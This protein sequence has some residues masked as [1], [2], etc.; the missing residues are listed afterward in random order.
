MMGR[1]KKQSPEEF[2]RD[3]ETRIGEKVLARN[4][5]RY[6]SGWNEFEESGGNPLW[7]L[8]IATEGGFRFHHFPQINWFDALS[9]LSS[10]WETPQEKTFFIPRDRIVAAEIR[11]ETSW[12]KRLFAPG[13][14]LL[15]IRYRKTDGTETELLAELLAET[16]TGSEGLI[17]GLCRRED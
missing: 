6:L 1:G 5:G 16:G 7:G 4:L 11:K 3:Y 17:A 12:W 15:V 13:S 8:L 10:G 9:R 14:P 2:W